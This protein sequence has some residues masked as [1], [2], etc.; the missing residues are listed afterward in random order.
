MSFLVWDV[1]DHALG[2]SV[3]AQIISVGTGLVAGAAVYIAGVLALRVPEARQ[4]ERLVR[5]RLGR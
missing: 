1:L 3:A 2:R 5:D 4:I